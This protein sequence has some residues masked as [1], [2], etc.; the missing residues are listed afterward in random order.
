MIE[1]GQAIMKL[2]P[3]RLSDIINDSVERLNDQIQQK[4]LNLV[5]HVPVKI[6]VLCDW[7]QTRRVLINLIHNAIKW[8]PMGGALTISAG[9]EGDEEVL[10]RGRQSGDLTPPCGPRPAPTRR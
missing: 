5:L 6:Q 9:Y 7:D 10:I 2:Y 8:S 3:T 4:N 1:S